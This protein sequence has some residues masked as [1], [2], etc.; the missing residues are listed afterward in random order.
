MT[1]TV[2]VISPDKTV[3]D[4][5]AEEVVLPST[6]GQLGILTGHAPLLTALDTGVMRV[7]GA[8]NQN[9]EAIALLG[10][11]AEVEENEVTILVNG[12]ERGDKINLD[13]A[14]TA[15]NQAEARLSQVSADDRQAQIQ[16]NQAF[17]R[18]RARFQAAGGLV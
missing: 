3:W 18:A 5:P 2:R 4:A 12:A 7:R 6:T 16:A 15:Y 9:W 10:G 1:L 14:R 13:E 17:K 11:F 8:K